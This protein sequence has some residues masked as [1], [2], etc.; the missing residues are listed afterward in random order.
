M[1][2]LQHYLPS[3]RG[4]QVN[5]LHS[6]YVGPLL[7]YTGFK[8]NNNEIPV[9]ISKWAL[10]ITGIIVIFYHGLQAYRKQSDG[11]S[12]TE[13]YG[14]QVNLLHFFFIGPLVAWTGWKLHQNKTVTDLEKITLLLLGVAAFGYHSY[15]AYKKLSN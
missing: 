13:N 7:M 15:N 10:L 8:L 14:F 4:T 9:N 6:L 1:N 12:I 11:A 5:L 3:D 2:L